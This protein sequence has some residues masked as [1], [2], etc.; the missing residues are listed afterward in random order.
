MSTWYEPK[1]ED[2]DVS[3]DSDELDVFLYQD[4]SGAV[5]C[6]LKIP[7][8]KTMLEKYEEIKKLRNKIE[9]T[10]VRNSL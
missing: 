10:N 5:Y 6:S 3:N 7:D 9:Q 8:I 2:L 1:L 4:Y